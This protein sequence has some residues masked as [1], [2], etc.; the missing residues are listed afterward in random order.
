MS[1]H[2]IKQIKPYSGL[3]RNLSLEGKHSGDFGSSTMTGT[4]VSLLYQ[5]PSHVFL[6]YFPFS[7]CLMIGCNP[8]FVL[9]TNDL[10]ICCHFYVLAIS[11]DST[12][13]GLH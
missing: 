3:N 10:M 13:M 6:T 4:H 11:E 2:N 12:R 1:C 7:R 5:Q 8:A 9:V